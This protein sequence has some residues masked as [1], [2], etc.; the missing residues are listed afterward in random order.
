MINSDTITQEL[1]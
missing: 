1:T